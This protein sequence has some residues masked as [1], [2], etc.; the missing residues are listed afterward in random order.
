MFWIG[1]VEELIGMWL[2]QLVPSSTTR[3]AGRCAC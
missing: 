3:Y 2:T 1:P